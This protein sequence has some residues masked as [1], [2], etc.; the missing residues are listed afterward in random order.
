MSNNKKWYYEAAVNPES[1]TITTKEG[2]YVLYKGFKLSCNDGEYSIVDIRTNNFYTDVK[3]KDL[4]VFKEQGFIQGAC[5]LMY[6]RDCKRIPYYEK[7]LERLHELKAE[8]E[9][10]LLLQQKVEFCKKRIRNC[11]DNI[12]AIGDLIVYF[13]DRRDKHQ[14]KYNF[15]IP[16]G[17]TEDES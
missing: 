11:S 10:K 3:P 14:K 9:K 13:S 7:R 6:I 5:Y 16:N 12:K 8:F 2:K 1:K 17:K 15:N 4:K